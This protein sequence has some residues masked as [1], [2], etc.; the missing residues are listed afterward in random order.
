VQHANVDLFLYSRRFQTQ[1]LA[2]RS[3]Q[4]NADALEKT[5]A[6]SRDKVRSLCC[7][8]R[9]C[10][11]ST[12]LVWLTQSSTRY[13]N[14][15]CPD[16]FS[17]L[18]KGTRSPHMTA[19]DPCRCRSLALIPYM[20]CQILVNRIEERGLWRFITTATIYSASKTIDIG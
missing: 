14:A 18:S 15:C 3:S 1:F 16:P 7:D 10:S 12:S 6:I 9:G 19:L 11:L 17:H 13:W 8:D 20:E 5:R 4:C 2:C